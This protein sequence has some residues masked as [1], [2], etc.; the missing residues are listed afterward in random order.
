MLAAVGGLEIAAIAGAVIGA[1]EEGVAVVTD[2]YISGAGVLA[3]VALCPACRG[4]VLPSHL[5][6]EPGHRLALDSLGLEPVLDLDMRLGEGS[7][8]ALAMG[9]VDAACRVMAGMATF[10]EAGVSEAAG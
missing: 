9:I 4:Y 2:G 10:A 1:A 3:A 6:A 7:G 5:S 8:A